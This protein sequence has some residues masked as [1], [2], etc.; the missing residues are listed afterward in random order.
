MVTFSHARAFL[1]ISPTAAP[2]NPPGYLQPA[3]HISLLSGIYFGWTILSG[4]NPFK[5]FAASAA[6]LVKVFQDG[7]RDFGPMKKA[8]VC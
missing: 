8:A 3:G 1:V 4:W 6:G 5:G 7:D 2:G